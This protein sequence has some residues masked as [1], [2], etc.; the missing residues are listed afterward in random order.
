MIFV[1]LLSVL[2]IISPLVLSPIYRSHTGSYPQENANI[3]VGGSIKVPVSL[4]LNNDDWQAQGI[5]AGRALLN[6][7]TTM[8]QQIPHLSFNANTVPFIPW[9]Y[10]R[11]IW[12]ADVRTVMAVNSLDCGPS[13]AFR[14]TGG[15]QNLLTIVS[16]DYFADASLA[17]NAGEWVG[18]AII[19]GQYTSN[20][21]QN[22]PLLS[23]GYYNTTIV[24]SPGSV[25]AD[26]TVVLIAGNGT[27]EGA[28]Q[29]II[30]PIATSRIV[31]VDVLACTSTT[32]LVISDCSIRQGNITNC[33]AV[34]ASDLPPNALSSDTGGVEKYIAFPIWVAT[35]LTSSP[36][37]STYS[38]TERF[39]MLNPVTPTLLSSGMAPLSYLSIGTP[40]PFY[41]VPLN[42]I[43]DVLFGQTASA[44]VQ[45]SSFAVVSSF[46]LCSYE[47]V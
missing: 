17:S 1:L 8:N 44:L 40:N 29:T 23:L 31:S 30:S 41:N 3:V 4:S 39:P 37:S 36:V 2:S 7:A 18:T 32:S 26:T 33:V 42:Y 22:D 47:S 9:A 5:I 15:S 25:S 27:L 24:V 13:A 38:F 11:A 21:L 19:A 16:S 10:I 28:Q 20:F 43:K 46:L 6:A 34:P 45:G 12:S 35:L 14:I